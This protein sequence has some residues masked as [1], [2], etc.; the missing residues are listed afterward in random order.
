MTDDPL[1]DH[2]KMR[3]ILSWR[4]WHLFN[5]DGKPQ[6]LF[7]RRRTVKDA[8]GITTTLLDVE[9]GDLDSKFFGGDAQQKFRDAWA[10]Y[11]TWT[12]DNA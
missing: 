12:K 11:A 8:K 2:L 9:W 10:E 3:S 1:T 7:R 6:V 5:L 4:F